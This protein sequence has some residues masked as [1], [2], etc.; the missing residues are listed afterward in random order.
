VDSLPK[1]RT[2][3]F[4]CNDW[5]NSYCVGTRNRYMT[6]GKLNLSIRCSL[7]SSQRIV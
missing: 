4:P 6:K 5:A 3:G 7:F 2:E 1:K